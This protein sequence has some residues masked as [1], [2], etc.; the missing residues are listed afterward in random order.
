[1]VKPIRF[2]VYRVTGLRVGSAVDLA[3]VLQD[4]TV[5]HLTTRVVAPLIEI[6]ADAETEKMTPAVEI[7]DTRYMIA[8]HL[9]TTIP[10]RSLGTL[11]ANLEDHDRAIKNAIHLLFF[12]V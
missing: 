8:T 10:V 11:V 7:G 12:G 9:L 5:A 6:G 4:D 3:V 1:V 2:G